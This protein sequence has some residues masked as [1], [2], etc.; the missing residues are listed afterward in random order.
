MGANPEALEQVPQP[1][2]ISLSNKMRSG[3]IKA[4]ALGPNRQRLISILIISCRVM[5]SKLLYHSEPDSH[6]A[7]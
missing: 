1:F 6:S 7:Q 4:L 5:L 2:S 3:S